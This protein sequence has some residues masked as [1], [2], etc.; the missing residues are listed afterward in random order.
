MGLCLVGSSNKHTGEQNTGVSYEAPV[1]FEVMMDSL[2]IPK[3]LELLQ[4][5]RFLRGNLKKRLEEKN[6]V[7][8]R[9]FLDPEGCG[10]EGSGISDS[11]RFRNSFTD[12]DLMKSPWWLVKYVE[13]FGID[14]D[15]T[16][17]QIEAVIA[18]DGSAAMDYNFNMR[19]NKPWPEAEDAI[20]QVPDASVWY[21]HNV[22]R[23]PEW[24]T[25]RERHLEF[26][27]RRKENL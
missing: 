4:Q 15:E 10:V 19:G 26:M 27:Q 11:T 23:D 17:E 25:W 7:E 9:T 8:V 21:A 24:G 14:D 13:I 22:L 3:H 20:A 1:F 6:P 12:E 2:L 18:T 16:E 5:Y